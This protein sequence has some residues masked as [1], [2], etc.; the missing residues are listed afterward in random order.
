ML[1]MRTTNA[2]TAILG[3][4][5]LLSGSSTAFPWLWATDAPTCV[6]HPAAAVAAHKTPVPDVSDLAM[7]PRTAKFQPRKSINEDLALRVR[8]N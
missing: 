8:L 7:Q 4:L 3:M 5:L 1:A 6:A 2:L